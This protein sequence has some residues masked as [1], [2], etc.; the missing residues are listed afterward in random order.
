V[1]LRPHRTVPPDRPA[2]QGVEQDPAEVPAEHLGTPLRAVVGQVEQHGAVRVEQA[3]RLGALVDDRAELVREAGVRE[4]ALTVVP[5]DVEPAALGAGLGPRVGLVDRRGN[6]VDVKDA[7][8]GEA[9]ESG[10]DDR[11]GCGHAL[12]RFADGRRVGPAH[13]E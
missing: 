12:L 4:R 5:V 13:L 2:G 7:G 6:P 1:T 9:A 8:E 10:A 11:D 3:Q